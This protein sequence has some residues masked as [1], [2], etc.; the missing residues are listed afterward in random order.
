MADVGMT[1]IEG[2]IVIM[3]NDVFM[4]SVALVVASMALLWSDIVGCSG[5]DDGGD[6]LIGAN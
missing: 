6:Q 2:V 4:I 1:A 5:A 3:I